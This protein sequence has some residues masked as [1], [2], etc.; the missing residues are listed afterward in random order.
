MYNQKYFLSE[1]KEMT[2]SVWRYRPS[3]RS[4]KKLAMMQYWKKTM[5]A[6]QLTWK[7]RQEYKLTEEKLI[8]VS[9]GW[10]PEASGGKQKAFPLG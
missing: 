5:A 4:Q 3:T 2:K 6:L 10:Q 1:K 8:A 7:G 9:F